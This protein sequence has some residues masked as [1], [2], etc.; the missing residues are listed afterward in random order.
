MA[1][2]TSRILKSVDFTETQKSK[3]LEI[4]RL[5]FVRIKKLIE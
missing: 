1:M 4:E 3:Y 5:F 2:M